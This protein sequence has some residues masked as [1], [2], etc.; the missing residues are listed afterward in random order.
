MHVR[1]LGVLAYL[2]ERMTLRPAFLCVH[3][4]L[5]YRVVKLEEGRS[6]RADLAA[7]FL[8]CRSTGQARESYPPKEAEHTRDVSPLLLR[9]RGRAAEG[10]Q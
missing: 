9:S 1:L 8:R 10:Y 2:M 4:Y 7:P 3:A 6:T 5:V